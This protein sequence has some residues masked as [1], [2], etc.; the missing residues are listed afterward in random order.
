MIFV[1]SEEL[2][3]DSADDFKAVR[4]TAIAQFA[5]M[6]SVGQH[7]HEAFAI[8]RMALLDIGK[9]ILVC[10]VEQNKSGLMLIPKQ[11]I[12]INDRRD[13]GLVFLSFNVFE[14]GNGGLKN[15]ID[16]GRRQLVFVGK[17]AIKGPAGNTHI[18]K[19]VFDANMG[20]AVFGKQS[21]GRIDK[22][23]P[24][25]VASPHNFRAL[26]GVARSWLNNFLCHKIRIHNYMFSYKNVFI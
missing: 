5:D 20:K 15:R 1:N 11:E 23:L 25:L 7:G 14:D 3:G 26:Y 18:F 12:K 21:C 6:F 13:D 2:N 10:R 9:N 8:V 4:G 16:E 17:E 24:H 22:R 19:Q